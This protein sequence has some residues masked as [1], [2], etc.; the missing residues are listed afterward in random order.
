MANEHWDP[1]RDLTALR[2]NVNR[3]VDETFLRPRGDG[4]VAMRELPAMDVYETDSAVT[5]E[6]HLP[7]VKRE[8]LEI[9][10]SGQNLTIKGERKAEAEEK[11][12]HYLRRE[13]YHGAFLRRIVLPEGCALDQ[14]AATFANGVLKITFPKQVATKPMRIELEPEETP[15]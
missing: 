12:A 5:V 3:L 4:P 14:S 13:V 8:E 11:D 1:L 9:T 10:L 15:V 6:A 2:D 7:G